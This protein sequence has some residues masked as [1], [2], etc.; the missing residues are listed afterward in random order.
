MLVFF[1]LSPSEVFRHKT[2]NAVPNSSATRC[3][4]HVGS[5][6]GR[7]GCRPARRRSGL[8]SQDAAPPRPAALERAVRR[9]A[10]A[11]HPHDARRRLGLV[12]LVRPR[13]RARPRA[14]RAHARDRRALNVCAR[15]QLLQLL[16]A[17]DLLAYQS[18]VAVRPLLNSHG[19]GAPALRLWRAV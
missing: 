10:P 2:G 9:S 1:S 4:L 5:C 3:E 12:R 17:A 14:R 8:R 18:V 11:A 13:P 15:R 6:E 7:R 19:R 16:R